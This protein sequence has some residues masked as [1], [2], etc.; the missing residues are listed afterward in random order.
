M[1]DINVAEAQKIKAEDRDINDL[2]E[3]LFDNV[4]SL[5]PVFIQTPKDAILLNL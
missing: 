5:Q 2:F 3:L 4:R 1:T